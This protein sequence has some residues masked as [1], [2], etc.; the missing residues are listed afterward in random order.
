MVDYLKQHVLG[1]VIIA[2]L[3]GIGTLLVYFNMELHDLRVKAA[4]TENQLTHI[5][6][7]IAE[8]KEDVDRLVDYRVQ[9]D[10]NP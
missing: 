8:I 3:I 4:V 1:S 5:Q 6:A 2:M 10:G 9:S 7:D